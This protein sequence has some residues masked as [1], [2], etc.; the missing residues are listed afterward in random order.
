MNIIRYLVLTILYFLFMFLQVGQF[1]LEV[2]PVALIPNAA[3]VL[4]YLA[5]FLRGHPVGIILGFSLG[6]FFDLYQENLLGSHSLAYVL[7]LRLAEKLGENT[8]D[9]L[10]PL[11]TSFVFTSIVYNLVL[12][13]I[14][15]WFEVVSA[16]EVA[17]KTSVSRS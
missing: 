16:I 17:V 2:L 8:A 13:M 9:S 1:T 14:V 6:F 12:F 11:L 4:L 15:P 3:F 10:V 7:S 5:A